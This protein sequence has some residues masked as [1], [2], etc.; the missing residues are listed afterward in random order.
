MK[1]IR[2]TGEPFHVR[3]NEQFTFMVLCIVFYK[4]THK[5]SNNMQLNLDFIARSVYMFRALSA[6]IV[7][8]TITVVDSHWYNIL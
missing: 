6:P 8:I 7:R 2:Q 3:F 1:Y 5:M 4:Y